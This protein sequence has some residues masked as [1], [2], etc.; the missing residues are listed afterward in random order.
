MNNY[1]K[2]NGYLPDQ[3]IIV[4]NFDEVNG[5]LPD[6]QIIVNNHDKV[7]G[8]LPDQQIIVTGSQWFCLGY[9]NPPVA[10]SV[11]VKEEKTKKIYIYI[12]MGAEVE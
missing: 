6:Q 1:D 3:Q 12:S 5:H 9:L 11:K 4:N 8:Y 2:V 10:L 7:N